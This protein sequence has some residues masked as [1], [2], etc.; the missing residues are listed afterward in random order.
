MPGDDGRTE[1]AKAGI[2]YPVVVKP[3]SSAEYWAKPFPN[4]KKAF[5]AKNEDELS[6]ILGSIFASGYG[7]GVILQEFIPGGDDGMRV[8]TTYSDKSGHVKMMCLGH[9]ML[10]EHTPHGIGNHTAIVSTHMPELTERFRRLLDGEGYT[11]FCNFDIKYNPG[12]GRYLAFD[13]NLRQGR[14]NY[15]VT[16]AGANI[17]ELVVRDLVFGEELPF[18]ETEKEVFWRSIPKATVWKY[19]K[20][21]DMVSLAKKLDSEKKSVSS[22]LYSYDLTRRPLRLLCVLEMLRRERVKYKKYCGSN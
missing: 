1:V 10:E 17:A 18:L 3:S 21:A 13:M 5:Y 9:V 2:K 15:Y 12:D 22:L 19:T 7:S 20:S 8:L 6:S 4:M 11:G 14:S 16:A